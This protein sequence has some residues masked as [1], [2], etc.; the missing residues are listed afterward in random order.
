MAAYDVASNIH[1]SLIIG[2]NQL[3]LDTPLDAEQQELTDLIKTSAAGASTSH[4]NHSR[5]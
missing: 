1:Q 4:H 5:F 3:M 2:V